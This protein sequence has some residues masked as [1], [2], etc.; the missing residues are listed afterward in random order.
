MVVLPGAVHRSYEFPSSVRGRIWAQA[1]GIAGADRYLRER[2][3]AV[4]QTI[5]VRFSDIGTSPSCAL[6]PR[7]RRLIGIA[8]VNAEIELSARTM[9]C[10]PSSLECSYC[11]M[12]LGNSWVKSQTRP[13]M[14]Q[15]ISIAMLGLILCVA[16]CGKP[17]RG[18][19]GDPG[20]EGPKGDRGE[21]GSPGSAG[22]PGPPG[23]QGPAGPSS[24][25]RIIRQSCTSTACTATCNENEVLVTAYCGPSR[26]DAKVLTERAV[27]CG[28]MPDPEHSPLVAVCVSTTPP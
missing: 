16:A 5:V 25:M 15:F 12:L 1:G 22:P 10:T 26:Q 28:I 13:F 6:L 20:P 24:Q 8:D 9:E 11:P 27:S 18:P 17:E 4:R 21:N 3:A 7:K 2:Y 19:K 14:R 23:P